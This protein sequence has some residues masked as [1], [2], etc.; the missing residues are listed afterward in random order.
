MCTDVPQPTVNITKWY[1]GV[2]V[3]WNHYTSAI[4]SL[5]VLC[6]AEKEGFICNRVMQKRIFNVPTC[7]FVLALAFLYASRDTALLRSP[8]IRQLNG[9]E[10]HPTVLCA[11]RTIH[12]ML[13]QQGNRAAVACLHGMGCCFTAAWDQCSPPSHSSGCGY[14]AEAWNTV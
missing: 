11:G 4:V 7:A 10:K 5:Q 6:T 8:G 12:A 3:F 1:P 9:W 14:H 13:W 2:A